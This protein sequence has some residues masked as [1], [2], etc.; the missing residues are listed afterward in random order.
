[1]ISYLYSLL[2]GT[3]SPLDPLRRV[4]ER[5]MGQ[6][7]TDDEWLSIR[8]EVFHKSISSSVHEQNFKFIYRIYLTPVRLHKMYP[9]VSRMCFKC[10][11]EIGT[12]MHLFWDCKK[13]K[14]FW[15]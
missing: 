10:K 8:E 11:S 2:S 12:L 14:P 1:Q 9:N 7:F 3:S 15:Q 5:D 6:S 4:W 13:I